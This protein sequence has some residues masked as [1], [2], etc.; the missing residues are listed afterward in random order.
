MN[1]KKKK[2]TEVLRQSSDFNLKM[3]RRGVKQ[4]IHTEI[5]S[6]VAKLK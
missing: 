4:A 1:K 3:L 2:K 5:P 6:K